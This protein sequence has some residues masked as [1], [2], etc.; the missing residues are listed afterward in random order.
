M[1]REMREGRSDKWIKE[2]REEK[3]KKG[4]KLYRIG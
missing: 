2:I 3:F 4:I 1:R